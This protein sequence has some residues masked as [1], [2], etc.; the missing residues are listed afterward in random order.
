V[1]TVTIR[2]HLADCHTELGNVQEAA[3][4]LTRAAADGEWVLGPDSPLIAALLAEA[5]ALRGS[6][7]DPGRDGSRLA[8]TTSETVG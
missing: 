3:E 7:R 2:I 1:S 4:G 8:G 5:A 6:H